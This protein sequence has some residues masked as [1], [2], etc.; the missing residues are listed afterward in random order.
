[1]ADLVETNG[2]SVVRRY[3]AED[4]VTFCTSVLAPL[5]VPPA[6]AEEVADCLVNAWRP[7]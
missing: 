2:H 4:L 3:A 1:M 6:G 7:E 5:G